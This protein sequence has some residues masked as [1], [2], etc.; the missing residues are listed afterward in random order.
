MI[1]CLNDFLKNSQLTIVCSPDCVSIVLYLGEQ[2]TA[3]KPG[4]P[5]FTKLFLNSKKNI[6]T[7]K[8]TYKIG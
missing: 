5:K 1:Y 6:T 4:N 8:N 7:K 2:K 3:K